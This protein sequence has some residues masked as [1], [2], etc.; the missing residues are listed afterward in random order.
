MNQLLS[1]LAALFTSVISFLMSVPSQN[2]NQEKNRFSSHLKAETEQRAALTPVGL[3]GNQHPQAGVSFS[4]SGSR[5]RLWLQMP[6]GAASSPQSSCC[7]NNGR[8]MEDTVT[9][10]VAGDVT[11]AVEDLR[12]KVMTRTRF[13]KMNNSELSF[14]SPLFHYLF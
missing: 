5:S 2:Q 1:S 13:P 7:H 9:S 12:L 14:F 6:R 4:A 10:I 8:Q 11:R 3:E